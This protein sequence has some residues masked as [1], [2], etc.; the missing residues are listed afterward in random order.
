MTASPA[1]PGAGPSLYQP[2]SYEVL[3]T[4]MAWEASTPTGS[5]AA[6][7][8]LLR[9]IS[10]PGGVA[11]RLRAAARDGV[12]NS[13]RGLRGLVQ[14]EPAGRADGGKESHGDDRGQ[15]FR[16]GHHKADISGVG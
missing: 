4:S 1:L 16:P 8:P 13:G 10:R 12:R 9:R 14:G 15:L 7:T 5:T 3:V 6:S 11:K 2:V